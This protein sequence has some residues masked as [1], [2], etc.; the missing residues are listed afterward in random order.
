MVLETEVLNE[1]KSSSLDVCASVRIRADV[2]R[3]LYALSMPEYM[4]AWLEMPGTERVECHSERWPFDRFRI[5]MFSPNAKLR[6]IYGSCLLSKPNRVTYLWSTS[7]E[8]SLSQSVVEIHILGGPNRRCALKL[9]HR[10][11]TIEEDRK[12]YSTMWQRSLDKLRI[13]MERVES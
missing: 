5:D 1:S 3:I 13:L 12:W 7:L 11:L 10:G 2:R 4:D 9:R 8:K 6:C